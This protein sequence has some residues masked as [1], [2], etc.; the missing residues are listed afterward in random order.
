MTKKNRQNKKVPKPEGSKT[1]VHFLDYIKNEWVDGKRKP[2]SIRMNDKLYQTF[3][4][5]SKALYGSTCA[6]I[7]TFMAAVVL[8]SNEKVHFRNTS[9]VDIGEIIINRNLPD[10]RKLRFKDDVLDGC[11]YCGEVSV[12]NFKY[13]ATDKVFPLCEFHSDYLVGTGTW[14][15]VGG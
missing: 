4:P 12:G 5:I 15:F 10:R 13:L 14:D 1:Y 9:S 2:I 11:R 7:E 6:A 8:A 3:K